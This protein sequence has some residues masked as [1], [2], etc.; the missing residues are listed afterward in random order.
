MA[1]DLHDTLAQGFTG[2][3]VQAEAAK[4]ALTR[5]DAAEAERHVHRAEELALHSLREARR[6]LRALRPAVLEALDLATAFDR[7]LEEMTSATSLHAHSVV[8]GSPRRLPRE[9][10]EHLLHI[11]QEALTNALR[12]AQASR[13]EAY[14]VYDKDRLRLRLMDDGGGFEV[15]AAPPGLGLVGMRER[16]GRMQ[17]DLRIT[18]A[19]GRGTELLVTVRYPEELKG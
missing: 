14:L 19:P 16:V 1:R 5:L 13:F 4:D 2:V 18:S 11:G 17:G 6:S 3:I 9:W 7:L 10:D 15:G 12:H 8:V